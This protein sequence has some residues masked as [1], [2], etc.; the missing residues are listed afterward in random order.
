MDG[1]IL[2]NSGLLSALT[3]DTRKPDLR[4]PQVQVHLG[5]RCGLGRAPD[6][7][8]GELGS[9]PG[10]APGLFPCSVP[11]AN[12]AND[13]D[14]LGKGLWDLLVKRA[15]ARIFTAHPS[16]SLLQSPT[17]LSPWSPLPGQR[18]GAREWQRVMLNGRHRL[19]K[20]SQVNGLL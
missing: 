11:Q 15:I 4:S 8:V 3:E 10:S 19:W 13:T 2:V 1:V 6:W 14:P 5:S 20:A 16:Q 18:L 17:Y 12:G 7:D 9:T